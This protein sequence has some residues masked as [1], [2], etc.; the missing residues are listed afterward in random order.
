MRERS[1]L[2]GLFDGCANGLAA[3]LCPGEVVQPLT[4]MKRFQRL[5]DRLADMAK[6]Q[7]LME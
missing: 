1:G 6:E 4:L 3:R 7:G 5:K 2:D